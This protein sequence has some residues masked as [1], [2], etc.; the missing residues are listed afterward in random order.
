MEHGKEPI[1]THGNVQ[2]LLEVTVQNETDEAGRLKTDKAWTCA[3]LSFDEN[4]RK[5][6]TFCVNMQGLLEETVQNATVDVSGSGIEGFVIKYIFEVSGSDTKG[7]NDLSQL[8]NKF[9]MQ[10]CLYTQIKK[11]LMLNKKKYHD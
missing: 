11:S 9:A 4:G 6:I 8:A 10:M 7:I 5:A 2:G 1:Q 3:S